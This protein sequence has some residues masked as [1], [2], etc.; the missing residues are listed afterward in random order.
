M[1]MHHVCVDEETDTLIDRQVSV[2]PTHACTQTY[3]GRL[4]DH[5]ILAISLSFKNAPQ[6]LDH[7]IFYFCPLYQ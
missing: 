4:I 6:I 2:S 7:N 1:K 5:V 3:A